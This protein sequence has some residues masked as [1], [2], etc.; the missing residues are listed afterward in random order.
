MK[1][2]SCN[3]LYVL[4]GDPFTVRW[5]PNQLGVPFRRQPVDSSDPEYQAVIA[6]MIAANAQQWTNK[7][8]EVG[9]TVNRLRVNFTQ[10]SVAF[11]LGGL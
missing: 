2:F 11:P 5:S 9:P 10:M 7:V 8:K 3:E 6:N 4:A 1:P